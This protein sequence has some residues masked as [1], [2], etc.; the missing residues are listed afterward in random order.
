MF[1]I[2]CLL[3]RPLKIAGDFPC[4]SNFRRRISKH[5]FDI[6]ETCVKAFSK[7][8]KSRQID[9]ILECINLCGL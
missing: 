7:K 6:L 4:K 1:I 5:V 3:N 2:D 9:V 8:H